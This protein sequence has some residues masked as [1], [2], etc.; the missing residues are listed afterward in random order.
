MFSGADLAAIINEAAIAATMANKDAI[1]QAD[2][3]EA[4]DKVRWG[5]ARRSRVIDEME[6][7]VTAYHEGG[8]ALAMC[9]VDQA[10]PLHKVSIIP[11][12]QALGATFQLPEKDRYS[13]TRTRVTAEIKVLLAGRIAES[14]FCGDIS[15]GAASDIEHATQL[16]RSMVCEW[17][18]SESLGPIRYG[19]E[20][21]NIWDGVVGKEHSDATADEIDHEI[22]T[23][24]DKAYKEV[25]ALLAANRD[26]LEAI[27][28]ALLKYETLSADDV[29][30]LIR[31]ESL[32]RPTVGDLLEAERNKQNAAPEAAPAKPGPSPGPVS[33]GTLP[34]PG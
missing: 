9:L 27:A 4:R 19:R 20:N 6:K 12:G 34:H 5:R 24:V 10:E 31:G 26:K 22:K 25:E 7:T 32:D 2:L 15:S 8:H 21:G 30:R 13:Y 11:R 29:K 16:A 33:P 1:E 23:I 17:G 14:L 28:R 18:M 3:E